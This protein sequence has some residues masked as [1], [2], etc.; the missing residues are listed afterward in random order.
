MP[1]YN[2]A[3]KKSVR[4]RTGADR[5]EI[6]RKKE[7]RIALSIAPIKQALAASLILGASFATV[8]NV[9]AQL[10]EGEALSFDQALE[11]AIERSPRAQL[12]EAQLEAVEGQ[13]DQAKLKPNP[14]IGA[15]LENVLGTGELQGVDSAELTVGISQLFERREKREKRAEL[16]EAGKQL[17]RWDYEE[18]LTELRSEVRHAFSNALIAQQN[19][20]LQKELLAVAE[21]SQAEVRRRSEAAKAS[22]IELSQ[23]NLATSRQG[24]EIS[25]A[26]RELAE[27]KI[28]LAALLNETDPGNFKL[29]GSLELE[30]RLPS[31]D[32]LASLLDKSPA[33]ARYAAERQAQEAAIEVELAEAKGDLELFGGV[34][35]LRGGSDEAA[36][37]V[38]IDIPWQIRNRNQGNIRSARAGLLAVEAE[39]RLARRDA[40]AALSIAYGRLRNAFDEWH[41]LDSQ[42][43]PS[44]ESTLESTQNGYQQGI[45]TLLSVLDARTALFEIRAEM[46][47]AT[48]AYIEAEAEIA[49]LTSSAPASK[50]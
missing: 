40:L 1:K 6:S 7:P 30:E 5:T 23:A 38:G 44:A 36:F 16:A 25:R 18:A 12:L 21:A 34:K 27:A 29:E 11:L 10:T 17:H 3:F 2:F 50:K 26:Q 13:I 32:E 39:R 47:E 4:P 35:Y 15:E 49:R 8:E 28:E 33:L 31:L 41:G 22:A 42:L 20:E 24:F 48:R 46:L 45:V 19:V 14:T 43:L 9:Q 37:V